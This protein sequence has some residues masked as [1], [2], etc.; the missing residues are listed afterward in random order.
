LGAAGV[1]L[2]VGGCVGRKQPNPLNG[3]C[4]TAAVFRNTYP[5]RYGNVSNGHAHMHRT[6]G[7]TAR[8]CTA[9][10]GTAR[11]GMARHGTAMRARTS[12][13]N[14]RAHSE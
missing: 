10:H 1:Q 7:G 8:H 13:G 3:T 2:R 14:A 6:R 12:D 9:R 11:Q 5:R 4:T